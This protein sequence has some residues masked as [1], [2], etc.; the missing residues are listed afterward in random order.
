MKAWFSQHAQALI[1]SIGQMVRA[2]AA[3]VLTVLVIAISLALP[4]GLLIVV[5]NL[6]S[7]RANYDG[8]RQV[9]ILLKP[10][11]DEAAAFDILARLEQRPDIERLELV[12]RDAA[13]DELR[14]LL[15]VSD[16]TAGLDSNPIPVT[17]IAQPTPDWSSI[18]RVTELAE[19]LKNLPEV[20]E[21]ILD[22]V[23]LKRLEALSALIKRAALILAAVLGLAVLLTVGNT[24]RLMVLGR[25]QEIL[26]IDRVGGTPAFIRRPF[27]WTGLVQGLLGG[28]V[29][30]G[31]AG[32]AQYA[33]S[34]RI[35]ALVSSY[36]GGLSLLGTGPVAALAT[37]ATGA[38]L[39]WLASW[40]AVTGHLRRLRPR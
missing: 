40:V 22:V 23:W 27:L 20:G 25:A 17:L 18:D 35:E 4:L 12:S 14:E 38:L 24:I 10:E 37:V 34:S 32:A 5:K 1:S 28:L 7:L 31:V 3:S 11:Y 30:L 2:P 8:G 6:D 29:A 26:V 36:Q 13:A 19:A 16:V 9:S 21:V 39:G 15:G 33:L